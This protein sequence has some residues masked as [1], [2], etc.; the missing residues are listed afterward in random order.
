MK[1]IKSYFFITLLIFTSS[2]NNSTEYMVIDNPDNPEKTQKILRE[3]WDRFERKM[4][5]DGKLFSGEIVDYYQGRILFFENSKI[6]KTIKYWDIKQNQGVPLKEKQIKEV[7]SY[8]TDE[9][10]RGCFSCSSVN[11]GLDG[12]RVQYFTNGVIESKE[13]FVMGLREEWTG[14]FEDNGKLKFKYSFKN[15]EYE[16]EQLVYFDNGNLSSKT[17]YN[18]GEKNG[19]S[20][21]YYINGQLKF[22]SEY[23]M[24][25]Q[26]GKS[27]GY[28]EDGQVKY[29]K[30][31]VDN[32]QDGL[33]IYYYQDGSIDSKKEY[34]KG[35]LVVVYLRDS[36]GVRRKVDGEWIDE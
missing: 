22:Q 15:G 5:L 25:K 3:G 33:E 34:S 4:T 35:E 10:V 14:Y 21:D 23:S 17:I 12:E 20:Q 18:G 30:N 2:C 16:G 19:V 29:E 13:I 31:W 6:K 26:E 32:K 1:T 7:K 9:D 8:R 28:F 36:N 27:L 11:Q 24:G